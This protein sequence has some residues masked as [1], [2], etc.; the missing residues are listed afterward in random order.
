MRSTFLQ[1]TN[2]QCPTLYC[3]RRFVFLK[4][5][6]EMHMKYP[7]LTVFNEKWFHDDACHAAPFFERRA[8]LPGASDAMKALA[9]LCMRVDRFH[10]RGHCP[11]CQ[12]SKYNVNNDPEWKGINM[13]ACEQQVTQHKFNYRYGIITLT[14]APPHC[15]YRFFGW[16]Y[17]LKPSFRRMGP[18]R[19]TFML[20]HLYVLLS[21]HKHAPRTASRAASYPARFLN[22]VRQR[23]DERIWARKLS[24]YVYKSRD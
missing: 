18:R 9:A 7:E 12:A 14:L 3:R 4:D 24:P 13:S 20:H 5:I 11:K 2:C 17:L 10:M 23:N 6:Y 22:R 15:N 8:K 19:F 16:M 1:K 21:L